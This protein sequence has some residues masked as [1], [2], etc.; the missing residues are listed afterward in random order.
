[1]C[2]GTESLYIGAALA[3]AS[4]TTSAVANNQS[5]KQKDQVA[6]EGIIKQG[7]INRQAVSN[8]D[9]ATKT[10]AQSNADAQQKQASTLQNFRQSLQQ[11]N[12]ISGGAEPGVPGASKAYKAAQTQATGSAG[13]YVGNIAQSAATT[14]G[15][16]LERV[17]EGNKIAD[18]AGKLGLLSGQSN[19]QNYL[20]QLK[21]RAIQPNPWLQSL[22]GLL[23]A[24]SGPFSAAAGAASADQTLNTNR[25][26]AMLP[27]TN[28]QVGAGLNAYNTA[29]PPAAAG[30]TIF[31]NG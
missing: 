28:A 19:E 23:G 20:T 8:V 31:G 9:Q 7:Q 15:T 3:A 1:M 30:S 22:S 17:D 25:A 12:G 5:N 6:A 18:T 14:E 13:N 10:V 4:A 24:A 26:N 29:N 27:A 21:E 11:S 2:Y 16:Q